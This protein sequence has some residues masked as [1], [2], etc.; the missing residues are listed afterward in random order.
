MSNRSEGITDN[1]E[2][3][4][5]GQ[6]LIA[7]I[8][9]N[10]SG[11]GGIIIMPILV[12]IAID[13]YGLSTRSAGFLG[14]TEMFG[15]AIG[16][17]LTVSAVNKID[18]RMIALV[19]LSIV[20]FGNLS[21]LVLEGGQALFVCRFI[22]G[23]G[24]GILC[25]VVNAIIAAT[26]KPGSRFGLVMSA[27]LCYAAALLVIIATLISYFGPKVLFLTM[28]LV[29]VGGVIACR[30]LPSKG[31]V[32]TETQPQKIQ[33]H[34]WHVLI[35]LGVWLLVYG[36]HIAIW[37][38]QERMGV[39]LGVDRML[40]GQVLGYTTIAGVLGAALAAIIGTRIGRVVPQVLALGVSVFAALLL[41]TADNL[42]VYAVAS[43]LIMLSWYFG[44]PYL[45]ALIAWLDPSGRVAAL[46]ATAFS[47]GAIFGPI[48]A[49]LMV[50]DDQ[51]VR[52]GWLGAI[53]YAACLII[54]MP[55][56]LAARQSDRKATS[57]EQ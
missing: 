42:F 18:R 51:F 9:V 43:N 47:I 5:G 12:G 27:S 37:T 21:S 1:R 30:W 44:V 23:I 3:H 56:A 4:D 20:M 34:Q 52:V 25:A 40:I 16:S 55:V 48:L 46:A 13:F 15:I 41:V 39:S 38:Y 35:V 26:S 28:A 53:F 2:V 31:P 7:A 11:S 57:V 36:G 24:G 49:A 33:S 29:S 10:F 6:T 54:I 32:R 19:G 45:Y 14:A 8:I 22:A 50:Q 17:I